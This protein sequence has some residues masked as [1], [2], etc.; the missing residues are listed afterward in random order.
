MIFKNLALAAALAL[1]VALPAEA[2]TYYI[3]LDRAANGQSNDH[4]G[5]FQ[6]GPTGGSIWG[7]SMTID[8][9]TYDTDFF[10][11]SHDGLYAAF[12][13]ITKMAF[14]GTT[15]HSAVFTADPQGDSQSGL[16]IGYFG[17]FDPATFKSTPAT[18]SWYL[19]SCKVGCSVL[20]SI[21][22]YKIQTTAF[23]EQQP[24]TA[25]VPLPGALPMLA[26]ALGAFGLMRRRKS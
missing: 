4:F 9:V 25:A 10:A 15:F 14:T 7:F 11:T 21:G 2:A 12:F 16:G 24:P 26:A 13:D 5:S 18:Q 3:A 6:S 19:T 20:D 8:G 22:S 1:G 17:T 23:A